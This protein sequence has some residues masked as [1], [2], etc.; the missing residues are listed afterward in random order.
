MAIAGSK[1]HLRVAFLLLDS[2][3]HRSINVRFI[4]I[5]DSVLNWYA[6]RDREK[7]SLEREMSAIF[8]IFL[9]VV[10]ALVINPMAIGAEAFKC[11]GPKGETVFS[12][13]PCG[14]GKTIELKEVPT[15]EITPVQPLAPLPA[16]KKS[17]MERY[18][19]SFSS[20]AP[21][22]VLRDNEGSLNVA[23][24]IKPALGPDSH[25]QLKVNGSPHGGPGRQTSWQLSDLE[26]GVHTLQV[27]VLNHK[28]SVVASAQTSFTLHKASA[29]HPGLSSNSPAQALGINRP[30]API[31]GDPGFVENGREPGHE[32]VTPKDANEPKPLRGGP[33]K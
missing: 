9:G 26:R 7:A 14:D 31:P 21:D 22:A 24:N 13:T 4:W 16:S 5:C 12:D 30:L 11:K 19:I 25:I 33:R 23:I 15:V 32:W 18:D 2:R 20:P 17:T 3:K 6:R 27:E 8:K 28:G 1:S 10:A 29:N